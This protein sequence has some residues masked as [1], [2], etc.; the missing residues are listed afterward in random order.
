M[1]KLCALNVIQ[2]L[3]SALKVPGAKM[4]NDIECPIKV[5]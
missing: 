5:F 4:T 2:K 3:Y 1:Q